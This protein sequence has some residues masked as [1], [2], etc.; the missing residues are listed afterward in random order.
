MGKPEGEAR[1]HIKS[2]SLKGVNGFRHYERKELSANIITIVTFLLHSLNL[3]PFPKIKC[4][5]YGV[6]SR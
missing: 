2:L 4:K 1:A 6:Q 5:T 3:A